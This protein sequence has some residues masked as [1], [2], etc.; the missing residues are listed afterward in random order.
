[1]ANSVPTHDKKRKKSQQT[2]S[3]GGFPQL[4]KENLQ[5][6][7]VNFILNV[8]K[9][10]AFSIKFIT[11]QECSYDSHLFYILLEVLANAVR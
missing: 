8:K 10:D 6:N 4:D 7:S 5:K 2:R 11:R 1:M 3:Q 9:S